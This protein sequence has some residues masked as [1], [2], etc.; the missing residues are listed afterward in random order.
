MIRAV[1]PFQFKLKRHWWGLRLVLALLLNGIALDATSFSA[2]VNFSVSWPRLWAIWLAFLFLLLSWV[3]LL[4][5]MPEAA[6]ARRLRLVWDRA[7]MAVILAF[8]ALVLFLELQKP[9][10]PVLAIDIVV[11]ALLPCPWLILDNYPGT[12]PSLPHFFLAKNGLRPTA[13]HPGRAVPGPW[14]S[15]PG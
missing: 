15:G 2:L 7:A 10:A 14:S 13:P 1:L 8:L 3:S 6:G 11:A 9:V 5:P 4:T 12:W